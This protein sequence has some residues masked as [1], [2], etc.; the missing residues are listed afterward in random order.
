M[1]ANQQTRIRLEKEPVQLTINDDTYGFKRKGACLYITDP[2]GQEV[3]DGFHDFDLFNYDHEKQLIL[4]E[5]GATHYVLQPP[6]D[7]WPQFEPSEGFGSNTLEYRR[8]LGGRLVVQRGSIKRIIDESGNC[9]V[10]GY[11][12]YTN[13]KGKLLGHLGTSTSEIKLP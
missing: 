12:K 6:T 7:H 9:L 4:G 8:D 1:E 2:S 3:S 11:Q 5:L 10:D 13:E